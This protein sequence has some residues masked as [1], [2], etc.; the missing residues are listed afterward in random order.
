MTNIDFSSIPEQPWPE[1]SDKLFTAGDDWWHNARLNYG[2]DDW[3][4]YVSGYKKAARLLVE[5]VKETQS[6]Q[7][8]LIFPIIFNYRQYLELHLKKMIWDCKR[9]FNEQP[10]FSK[11][12]DL[13]KLWEDCRRLLEK[14]EPKI[15]IHDL[16]AVDEG[17]NQFCEYDPRSMSFRYPF[18]TKGDKS[19]PAELGHINIRNFSDVVEKL[20]NFFESSDVMIS[21]YLDYKSDM[22]S[23]F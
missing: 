9:L 18:D 13:N 8:F 14:V 12:H 17:I 5:H 22:E 16:E 1:K 21:V 7:D 23:D 4:W 20:G 10:D 19:L 2:I 6:D 15:E 3:M 11:T